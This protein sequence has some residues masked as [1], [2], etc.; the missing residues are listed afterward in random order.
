MS[1]MSQGATPN[2]L[3]HKHEFI[4][5]VIY[6]PLGVAATWLCVMA[7]TNVGATIWRSNSSEAMKMADA[8]AIKIDQPKIAVDPKSKPIPQYAKKD[9]IK[10]AIAFDQEMPDDYVVSKEMANEAHSIN[11]EFY[12]EPSSKM[13]E[14][15]RTTACD[16]FGCTTG[17]WNPN[18]SGQTTTRGIPPMYDDAAQGKLVNPDDDFAETET[19]PYYD[20]FGP[21]VNR[22]YS[23][24]YDQGLQNSYPAGRRLEPQMNWTQSRELQR[25]QIPGKKKLAL[26]KRSHALPLRDSSTSKKLVD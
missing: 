11:P 12:Q 10:P 9:V 20:N 16:D 24:R 19:T 4:K 22:Y 1:I 6:V 3:N 18:L 13:R 15:G 17:T 5:A 23:Y 7:V 25:S 8:P 14:M 26:K 21:P 2:D